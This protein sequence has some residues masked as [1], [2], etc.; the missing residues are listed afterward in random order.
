MGGKPS[1]QTPKDHRLKENK[2]EA[3]PMMS[4]KQVKQQKAK[5]IVLLST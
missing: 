1:R 4:Q 2:Q 3:K 5:R